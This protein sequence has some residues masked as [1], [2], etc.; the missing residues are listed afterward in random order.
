M[1]AKPRHGSRRNFLK[2]LMVTGWVGALAT[3]GGKSGAD[4]LRS[5]GAL[6]KEAGTSRG[7]RE[8]SHVRKYYEKASR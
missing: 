7:Y 3:L 1:K 2:Q 4:G 6:E 5:D 8:T